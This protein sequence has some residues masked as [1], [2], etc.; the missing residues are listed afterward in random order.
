MKTG[1][2]FFFVLRKKK[3]VE[4]VWTK[5]ERGIEILTLFT[6]SS[7]YAPLVMWEQNL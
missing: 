2:I 6:R 3:I 4:N 7:L 5:L 1:R